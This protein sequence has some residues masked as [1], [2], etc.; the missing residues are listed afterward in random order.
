[1]AIPS[2]KVG[3]GETAAGAGT[4]SGPSRDQVLKPML[5]DGLLEMTI[6][7]KPTSS[8]QRYRTTD[9]GRNLLASLKAG[10]A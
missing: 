1:M 5:A 3:A 8:K 4:K 9:I 10:G 2:A 6:P 7:D